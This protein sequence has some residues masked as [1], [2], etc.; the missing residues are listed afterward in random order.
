MSQEQLGPHHAPSDH[1][2][3]KGERGGITQRVPGSGREHLGTTWPRRGALLHRSMGS[4]W[5]SHQSPQRAPTPP[6][7]MQPLPVHL[8]SMGHWLPDLEPVGRWCP[9]TTLVTEVGRAGCWE[10]GREEPGLA[11]RPSTLLGEPPLK[12]EHLQRS[13]SSGDN[14]VGAPCAS[15][16]FIRHRRPGKAAASWLPNPCGFRTVSEEAS[17]TRGSGQTG[18]SHQQSLSHRP[19]R[20]DGR[21]PNLPPKPTDF[22]H[23]HKPAVRGRRRARS[24]ATAE[25]SGRSFQGLFCSPEL[26]RGS[27][28]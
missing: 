28:F 24:A 12:A 25:D 8:Y 19:G 9:V 14:G 5:E 26:Q 20:K 16:G 22:R 13:V 11:A 15:P 3:S 17:R 4:A 23:F 2:E 10:Q 6:G 7:W 18:R 1:P 27:Y 21:K